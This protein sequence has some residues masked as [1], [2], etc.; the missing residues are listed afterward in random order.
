MRYPLPVFFDEKEL[1]KR[2]FRLILYGFR[3]IVHPLLFYER[4]QDGFMTWKKSMAGNS[5]LPPDARTARIAAG[6][7]LAVSLH[8]F[9]A[10]TGETTDGFRAGGEPD[11]LDCIMP[12]AADSRVS[13]SSSVPSPFVQDTHVPNENPT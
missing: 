4:N 3:G 2:I 1:K 9:P 11:S 5:V 8:E 12:H 7:G 13:A 6:G 10:G